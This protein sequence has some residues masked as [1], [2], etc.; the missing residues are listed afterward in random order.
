M[1]D[2]KRYDV[3]SDPQDGPVSLYSVEDENG[4]FVKYDDHAAISAELQE[5]VRALAAENANLK[6]ACG[7]DGIYID[8]PGCTH[9]QYTEAPETPATD[10]VL[11][12]IRAQAVDES[13]DKNRMDWLCSHVVEVRQPLLHGSHAM[14]Y[15]KCDSDDCEEYHSM[16]REQVDAAIRAGEQS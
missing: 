12:E 5:Q 3:D 9:S 13:D 7:G 10:A 11:R 4:E 15:A 2:I 8:C 14:F 16:L 1:T 6:V